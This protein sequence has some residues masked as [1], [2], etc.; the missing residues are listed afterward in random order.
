MDV[1]EKEDKPKIADTRTKKHEIP[2]GLWLKCKSCG[3]MLFTKELDAN[4]KTCQH[5]E[6]HFGMSAADRI[7]SLADRNVFVVIPG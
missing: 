7:G 2:R 6:Y 5:C 1:F 4:L 3:E